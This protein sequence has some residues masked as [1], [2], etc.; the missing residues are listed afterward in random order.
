MVP[1]V[2]HIG[3]AVHDLE[4]AVPLWSA[5]LGRAPGGRESVEPEGVRLVFFGRGAGRVELLEPTHDDSPVGRFLRRR[6]PGLHHVC[7]AVDDLEGAVRRARV[8]GAELVPPG[9][10]EGA[11][12]SRVA[13]LHPRS[14]GGIL[15]ELS[16]REPPG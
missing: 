7:L 12:G 3:V 9:I 13:F 4:R 8:E 15:L 1:V 14:T 11:G 5:I 10:R 2:D 6:G 16:E